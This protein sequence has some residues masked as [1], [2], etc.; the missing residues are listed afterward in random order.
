MAVHGGE[1]MKGLIWIAATAVLATAGCDGGGKSA[2]TDDESAPVAEAAPA[3]TT[4]GSSAV[5]PPDAPAP[6]EAGGSGEAMSLSAEDEKLATGQYYDA[7]PLNPEPGKGVELVV[8]SGDFPPMI[9]LLD[10][11]KQIVSQ[12]KAANAGSGGVY[13][14]NFEEEFPQGGQHYVLFTTEEAGKTGSYTVRASTTTTTVL[15]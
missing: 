2:A 8:S 1:R 9:I 7:Y 6:A 4:P 14:L 13:T 10:A 11:D 12:S 3:Q 15:N 5:A